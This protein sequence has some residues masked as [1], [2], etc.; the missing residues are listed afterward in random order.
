MECIV[1]KAH[2]ENSPLYDFPLEKD[3]NGLDIA[4]FVT[5]QIYQSIK[6]LN[7]I[8]VINIYIL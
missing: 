6:I 5:I 3:E 7:I 2:T 4:S 1:Y 8:S